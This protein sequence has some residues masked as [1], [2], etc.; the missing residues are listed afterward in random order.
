MNREEIEKLIGGYAP[1]ILTEDER[2]ALFTAALEDDA[3]FGALADEQA[4][5]DLLADP[6]ARANLLSV[7]G[8]RK[9]GWVGWL[10][11]PS[12]LALAG[13][14]AATIVMVAVFVPRHVVA[15]GAPVLVARREAPPALPAA[16]PPP[17]AASPA[18]APRRARKPAPKPQ[19]PAPVSAAAVQ[20]AGAAQAVAETNSAKV[21]GSMRPRMAV[22]PAATFAAPQPL[23]RYTILRQRSA[24]EFLP[25][26]AGAELHVGDL[27]CLRFESSQS[28]SLAVLESGNGL[29][30]HVL[31]YNRLEAGKPSNLQLSY[32][33]P[34]RRYF[35]AVLNPGE[36]SAAGE[37][38]FTLDVK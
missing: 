38:T 27:I 36:Q 6:A 14:L 11:K 5:R 4:L 30:W 1:G 35:R 20:D 28:G 33:A 10:R 12:V 25:L 24:D 23:V 26:P 2:K 9:T 31:S 19:A 15:P 13:G 3:L 34:G 22:T 17:P 16:L 32:K 7:L 29:A 37:V 21:A 8:E 18:P